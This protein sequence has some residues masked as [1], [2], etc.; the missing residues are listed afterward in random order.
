MTNREKYIIKIG[1]VLVEVT[2]EI[3]DAYYSVERHMRTLDEKD[4]RNGTVPYSNLDT[5]E[6]LG[7]EMLRD[8]TAE[9]VEDEALLRILSEQLHQCLSHLPVSDQE[10][11]R[12][13]YFEDLSEREYARQVG[14]SQKG[15]NK[16]K[17]K[18][19]KKLRKMVK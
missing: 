8:L 11:I 6:T 3:Y 13:I 9:P 15:V 4:K 18:I 12:A 1:D 5:K 14:L 2:R 10:L 7:V 17:H 19:L 16:R